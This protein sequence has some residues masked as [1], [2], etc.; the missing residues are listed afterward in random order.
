MRHWLGPFLGGS[1]GGF[2][3]LLAA[4]FIPA[5]LPSSIAEGMLQPAYRM[6]ELVARFV[7]EVTAAMQRAFLSAAAAVLVGYVLLS[8]VHLAAR[9]T[10]PGQAGRGWRHVAWAISFV[11]VV[12][13]ATAAAY[14][15]LGLWLTTVDDAAAT[16]WTL[17]VGLAA[18]LAYWLLSVLGSERMMRSAVPLATRL[19][20]P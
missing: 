15:S 10:G 16:Q 12:V 3:L 5:F 14:F 7:P 13:T 19:Y 9:P 6:E 18:A 20:P 1:A 4:W 11:I 17:Y 8:L 2:A